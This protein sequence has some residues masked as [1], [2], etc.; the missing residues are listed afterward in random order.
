MVKAGRVR[1][2]LV[3]GLAGF[4]GG[5]LA[6]FMMHQ[7]DQQKF[8]KEAMNAEPEFAQLIN[9]SSAERQ[10]VL[11]EVD[12]PVERQDLARALRATDSVLGYLDLQAHYGVTIGK[13]GRGNDKGINL[14]YYGSYVYWIVE[15]LIVA[16][17]T[18]GMVYGATKE[19]Y[20]VDCDQW[21][22]PKV[23]GFFGA[24]PALASAAVESGDLSKIRQTNPTPEITNVRLTAHACDGCVDK[25]E[26]DLKLELLTTDKEGKLQTKTLSHVTYP[27]SALPHLVTLFQQS[28]P[29][30]AAAAPT[31]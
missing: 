30:P 25:G 19:P 7:F 20:C 2:P 27:A 24:E 13:P 18:Y 26:A 4:L 14:G 16:G 5:A 23:L 29:P 11:A 28:P 8:R 10:E 21:K 6:M 22:N 17:V 1:N 3:G 12:D 9:M 31:A 15:L